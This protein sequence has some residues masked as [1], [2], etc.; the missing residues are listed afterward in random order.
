MLNH[1]ST[2]QLLSELCLCTCDL[3]VMDFHINYSNHMRRNGLLCM[4]FPSENDEENSQ[5]MRIKLLGHT[6]E[7]GVLYS[8]VG[9]IGNFLHF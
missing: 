7:L 9:V 3:K 4:I 6:A 2:S 5:G 8:Y 1:S